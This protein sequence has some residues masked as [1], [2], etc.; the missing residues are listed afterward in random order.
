MNAVCLLTYATSTCTLVTYGVWL[1]MIAV[2]Q[3]S[4]RT[5]IDVDVHRVDFCSK[6]RA[7]YYPFMQAYLR[8]K[9]WSDWLDYGA[10]WGVQGAGSWPNH[11]HHSNRYRE[12]RVI[13]IVKNMNIWAD[14]TLSDL[15]TQA[16]FVFL[17]QK[18]CGN[19]AKLSRKNFVI[20]MG[21]PTFYLD[22][23]YYLWKNKYRKDKFYLQAISVA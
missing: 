12:H 4:A 16:S 10:V 2:C 23:W 1:P 19:F 13:M 8:H 7:N 17:P 14:F 5:L 15:K 11:I 3:S 18:F 20:L 6:N 21:L 22:S 9:L